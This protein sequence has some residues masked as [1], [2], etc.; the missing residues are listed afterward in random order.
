MAPAWMRVSTNVIVWSLM[1]YFGSVLVKWGQRTPVRQPQGSARAVFIFWIV[2]LIPWL[3]IA[4]LSAMAFDGG[5][6]AEAYALVWSVWTY[7]IT[8]ALTA[9]LRRW[10]V[11]AVWLPLLNLTG[12]FSSGLLHNPH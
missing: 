4:P 1:L 3:L 12:C 2:L 11:W 6:T 7:P 5:Y 10:V 9:V 8:V